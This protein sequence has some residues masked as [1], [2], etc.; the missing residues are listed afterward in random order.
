M[1]NNVYSEDTN[2]IWDVNETKPQSVMTIKENSITAEKWPLLLKEKGTLSETIDNIC[3]DIKEAGYY[4][5]ILVS[6]GIDS[7][8]LAHRLEIKDAYTLCGKPFEASGDY[9]TSVAFCKEY[10]IKLHA[11]SLPKN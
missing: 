11:V 8:L 5:S 6:G 3:N 10:G 7:C 4:D 1:R 9:T 2:N